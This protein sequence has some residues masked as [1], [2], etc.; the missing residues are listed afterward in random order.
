MNAFSS[1]DIVGLA[2]GRTSGLCLSD[3]VV[4]WLSVYSEVQMICTWSS[5]CHCHPI[6]S[7][8]IKVQI[9]L[10]SLVTAY[11]GCCGKVSMYNDYAAPVFVYLFIYN[12][13]RDDDDDDSDDYSGATCGHM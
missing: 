7:G 3:D 10:T 6:N 11:P 5:W 2:S 8:F 1:F 13:P 12:K 4:A 9:G